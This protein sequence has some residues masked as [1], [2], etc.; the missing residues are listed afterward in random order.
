MTMKQTK[1]LIHKMLLMLLCLVGNVSVM[2]ASYDFAVKNEDGVTIYYEKSGDNVRVVSGEEKYSGNV[3]VPET[4]C[5]EGK[6]YAVT[7]ISASTF[8]NCTTLLSVSLPQSLTD[9]GSFAFK[10]CILLKAITVPQ[11]VKTIGTGV[12]SDCSNLTGVC[13]P[14]GVTS[15]GTASFSGCMKLEKIDFPKSLKTIENFAFQN[16]ERLR[17]VIIP[18]SV[19]S[20]GDYSFYHCSNLD[21]VTLGKSLLSIG[22]N[23]FDLDDKIKTIVSYIEEP[24][25]LPSVVWSSSVWDGISRSSIKKIATLY[26]P[27]GTKEAYQSTE[28]WGFTNIVE[29]EEEHKVIPWA[30][31]CEN[32]TTLYFLASED[33]LKVGDLYEGLPITQVWSGES[34]TK[35]GMTELPEW[36]TIISDKL[37]QV[38]FEESFKDVLP[39]CTRLW[40]TGCQYLVAIIGLQ[41]LNTSNVEYMDGMFYRCSSLGNL[42]LSG[43]NTEKARGMNGMFYGC[44][45]LRNLDLSTFDTHNVLS[46]DRM[47]YQCENLEK[48]SLSHFDVRNDTTMHQM[49][50]Y[51]ENLKTIELDNWNTSNVKNMAFMFYGCKNL[52][53]LDVSSFETGHVRSTERMFY[54]C[55]GLETLNLGH[56]DTSKD[57]TMYCMFARCNNLKNIDM[58]DW[59]TANVENMRGMFLSCKNLERLELTS[60]NTANVKT[61]TYMFYDCSKLQSLDLSSFDT[62][63]VEHMDSMFYHCSTLRTIFAGDR[64][65]TEKLLSHKNMFSQCYSL[66]GGNGTSYSS[67]HSDA[68]YARF[69][70]E[71]QPGYFTKVGQPV[72]P[73]SLSLTCSRGGWIKCKNEMLTAGTRIL[74]VAFGDTLVVEYGA[75]NGYK[76]DG[77]LNVE[78][79]VG[80]SVTMGDHRCV[81][82]GMTQ[83]V[84]I[85]VNF[86]RE[87]NGTEIEIVD[88]LQ[89]Y[90]Y[91][92]DLDFT[93]VDGLKAYIASGF[94]PETG[95]V[96]MLRVN[97]VPAGTGVLLKGSTGNT[98]E[99]P[100]RET[101]FIYSNLLTGTIFDTEIANGYVLTDGQFVAVS[102]TYM[103]SA[104]N[105]YL[106]LPVVASSRLNMLFVDDEQHE[107]TGGMD[108][109]GHRNTTDKCYSLQGAV[110]VGRPTK[111]GV[112]VHNGRKIVIK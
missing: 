5:S 29:M 78:V 65:S 62:H 28:G 98:Y 84:T 75:F 100:I 36:T 30:V 95:E 14:F 52:K 8:E 33:S 94:N 77:G 53:S 91:I 4:V 70:E 74:N 92:D 72:A 59:N 18:D 7:M 49:F 105:A 85:S 63:N 15:I 97:S 50:A 43:F 26:V 35:A 66:V 9:I 71:G 69:D 58:T 111:P 34:V 106:T 46:T 21:S 44:K 13:L 107:T 41:H 17:N 45:S 24:F 96:V 32:N 79:K 103:L 101:S 82:N 83:P 19:L 20:I 6:T 42:N 22:N 25:A 87:I 10:G 104:G 93:E 68:T 31:W 67:A 27:F 12:F 1:N 90:C 55:E 89:T 88:S 16:C 56:F 11:K 2:A 54:L 73:L 38:I 3:V 108:V 64:W 39:T 60:F 57:T 112:Y 48:L 86:K 80:T 61:M 47:F 40:F 23:A 110:I 51:C 81:I 76:I 37:T 99:V 102:G 109:K